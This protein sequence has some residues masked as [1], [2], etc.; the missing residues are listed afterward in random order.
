MNKIQQLNYEYSELEQLEKALMIKKCPSDP[1]MFLTGY[2]LG[3]KW[4][5]GP[6]RG[7]VWTKD[8]HDNRN[9]FKRFPNKEYLWITVK[10]WLVT[11]ILI[12]PKSRQILITWL[13]SALHLWAFL[14]HRGK[15]IYFQSKKETDANDVLERAKFIYDKLPNEMIQ[16]SPVLKIGGKWS[17]C[18]I[19]AESK[20]L[21]AYS[22]IRAIPQGQD[23]LRGKTISEL[24]SD[25]TA[26]QDKSKEAYEAS[27]PAIDGG[28]KYTSASTANGKNFF[29]QQVTGDCG[30]AID[31]E[32]I[33]RIKRS[34]KGIPIRKG[35]KLNVNRAGFVV[36]W[37]HYS[38]DP[39]KDPSTP[40]GLRW[41]SRTRTGY[42]TEAWE[43]E[44]EINF[45]MGGGNKVFHDFKR[46]IH[47]TKLKYDAKLILYRAWDFGYHHPAVL[48]AQINEKDQLCILRE[49][50]GTDVS[51]KQF[52]LQVKEFT[53]QH[54]PKSETQDIDMPKEY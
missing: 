22:K 4:I 26:F 52:K 44:Y 43:R 17:Y 33:D 14:F 39:N 5:P 37:I 29:Y 10:I 53:E 19:F 25:E 20:G 48:F 30:E 35:M 23:V 31:R 49:C 3:D 11:H 54:F 47:T 1:W 13:L 16:Q 45:A 42:S 40:K 50:Q 8:E 6:S 18:K 28:G 41:Y 15:E 24:F 12:I 38:A 51:L 9:P 46:A 32:K 7:F 36:L 27:K 21:N 34:I 2:P